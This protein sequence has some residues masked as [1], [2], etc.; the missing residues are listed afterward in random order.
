MRNITVS[1][2]DGVYRHARVFA[3]KSNTSVSALVAKFLVNMPFFTQL[4][5]D[6]RAAE[7]ARANARANADASMKRSS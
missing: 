4:I 2:D 6:K 7:A 3:A 1:V 5:E